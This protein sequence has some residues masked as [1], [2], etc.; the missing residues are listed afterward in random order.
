MRLKAL[1]SALIVVIFGLWASANIAMAHVSE[2][3]IVLLLPTNIYIVS[4]CLAVIAS[5]LLVTLL[6][7]DRVF[8]FFKPI[9]IRLP[10]FDA[11]FQNQLLK[12]LVSIVALG[13]VLFLT[14]IGVVGSRDPLVNMLPLSIWTFWWIA[15][16]MMHS[17]FGNIW[18]WI[19][20]WTG[21]YNQFLHHISLG[22]ELPRKISRWPAIVIFVAFYAFIIA[23]IAP[24]DPAR[25]AN[26]VLGYVVFTFVGMITFG[27]Q[28]W[29]RQVECFSILFSLLSQLSPV[30][31]RADGNGWQIG[32]PGWQALQNR[33]IFIT[34]AFFL[35]SVL[36]SGSFDGVNET[37]W[38]LVQIDVNPLAFPGRSAVVWQSTSGIIAANLLL[39][40]IFA[41]CIWSGIKIVKKLRLVKNDVQDVDVTFIDLFS[42]LAISV[43]PIAAVYHASHYLT[44]LMVNGQYLIAAL[45]DPL[46]TGSNYLG[47]ENYQVTTGYLND[48]ASVKRIWMTQASLVVFGH[49]IAVLMAHFVIA[50][51]FK[52]WKEAA[53]F[54]IPIAIFMATYTWFGLWLLAA[55]K[56]A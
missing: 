27:A 45:S 1:L 20:P 15:I 37:F 22:V 33:K 4:G 47:L 25:L 32:L 17:V 42:V 11:I 2:Q 8:S 49:I 30:K 16:F 9:Q 54:H 36:G 35:L 43:L 28:S 48:I 41:I 38:W 6:P 7:H 50:E 40:G 23:D 14:V 12:D 31:I 56:G 55:P 46:G 52:T 5:M 51:R 10:S 24:D 21:L 34:E 26:F 18:A 53:F 13:I 29:C 3:G 19:N 44:T 39:Y